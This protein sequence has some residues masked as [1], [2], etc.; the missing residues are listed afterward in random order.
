MKREDACV[1]TR[2]KR[3]DS[4]LGAQQ[5]AAASLSWTGSMGEPS[6]RCYFCMEVKAG[7]EAPGLVAA[8]W[9]ELLDECITTLLMTSILHV[10]V[11]ARCIDMT[12]RLS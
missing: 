11:R 5:V 7:G 10:S 1:P 8:P 6:V 3:V 4:K 12:T 9:N 2:P